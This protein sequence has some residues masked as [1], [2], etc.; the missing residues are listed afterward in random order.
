V[1]VIEYSVNIAFNEIRHRTRLVKEY[2]SLP[3]VEADDARLG[4]VFI[5][6]LVNAAHAFPDANTDA[7]EVRIVTSTDLQGRAVVEVRDTG[8]GIPPALLGRV[9]DP[10]FTTQPIGVGT[11]LGLAIGHNIVTR[12]GGEITVHSELGRGTTFR[13]ALPASGSL[14]PSLHATRTP[15]EASPLRPG[16]VLV[17]DDEPA[18]GMA[19]RR[20]LRHHDVTVVTTAQ[21]ALDLLAAGKDFDV[22]LS[23]LMM[24]GMSG[25]ELYRSLVQSHPKIA[26]RVVFV[27]GGAL[28]AEA[29]AFLDRVGN[30]RVEK[31][32]DSN[33]LRE[34]I[35]KLVARAEPVR[36][37]V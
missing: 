7:N 36:E 26:S 11:G 8:P 29:N 24:P 13:V 31:P 37:P 20:V 33:R 23:D 18:V 10:F 22:V 15:K 30:N 21:G 17:V 3:L 16:A 28:T 25:M 9:F 1:P 19:I 35:Q 34:L 27:T 12:M 4:H 6:L 2:G 5:N 14:D 32:F